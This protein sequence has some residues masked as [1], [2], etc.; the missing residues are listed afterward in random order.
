MHMSKTDL[1]LFY[2]MT[3]PATYLVIGFLLLA[4][5]VWLGWWLFRGRK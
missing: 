2:L 1:Y 4:L 5:L 3:N